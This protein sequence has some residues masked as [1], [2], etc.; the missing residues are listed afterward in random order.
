MPCFKLLKIPTIPSQSLCHESHPAWKQSCCVPAQSSPQAFPSALSTAFLHFP[1]SSASGSYGT[2]APGFSS[3]LYGMKI[4][5]LAFVTKTRVRFFKLDRWADVQ[6]PEKR[7]IK[8]GSNIS[9]HHRSL[10]ARVFHDRCVSLCMPCEGVGRA[11]EWD[12]WL[13]KTMASLGLG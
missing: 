4:A 5:N 2:P 12:S 1:V 8:P 7:R 11:R 10:L 6:L 13:K 9:K 3:M